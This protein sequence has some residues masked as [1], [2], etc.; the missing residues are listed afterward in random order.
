MEYEHCRNQDD[1]YHK[2]TAVSR[3]NLTTLVLF[4]SILRDMANRLNISRLESL[5]LV[6]LYAYFEV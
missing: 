3:T 4:G 1:G 5:H 6:E 2:T